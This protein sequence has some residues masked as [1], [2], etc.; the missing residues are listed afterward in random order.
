MGVGVSD[1]NDGYAGRCAAFRVSFTF[2]ATIPFRPAATASLY[3]K[4]G[5]D[6]AAISGYALA[7][8]GATG[9]M[10]YGWS[11]APGL[12]GES[13]EAEVEVLVWSDLVKGRWSGG[14]LEPTG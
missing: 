11:V 5:A 14:F 8:R 12:G 4:E 9:T 3:R 1:G 2:P 6:Q 7:V 10:T 13:V